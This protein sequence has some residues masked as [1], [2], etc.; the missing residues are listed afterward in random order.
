MYNL[1]KILKDIGRDN[2]DKM[3]KCDVRLPENMEIT[4]TMYRNF[5]I[6]TGSHDFTPYDLFLA[7]LSS[8][9]GDEVEISICDDED[10]S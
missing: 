1:E 6:I 3:I 4:W 5:G 8:E 7:I 9:K 2:F 10:N